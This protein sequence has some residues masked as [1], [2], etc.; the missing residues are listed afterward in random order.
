MSIVL[1]DT[2]IRDTIPLS[3]MLIFQQFTGFDTHLPYLLIIF[4]LF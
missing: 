2:T 1:D 4:W 3:S